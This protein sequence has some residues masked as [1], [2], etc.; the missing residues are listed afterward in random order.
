MTVISRYTAAKGNATNLLLSL[1]LSLIKRQSPGQGCVL[2]ANLF[3]TA[4]DRIL[5]N[6]THAL[7]LG[8][9]YMMTPANSSQI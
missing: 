3:N 7:I 4:N 8:V 6:T 9:N 2:A 5:N 1:S